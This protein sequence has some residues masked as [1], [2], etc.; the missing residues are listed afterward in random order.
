MQMLR[1][2]RRKKMMKS[3]LRET[4][5]EWERTEHTNE[6]WRELETADRESN[7]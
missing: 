7:A 1:E 4:W 3:A 5:K 6:R 2:W